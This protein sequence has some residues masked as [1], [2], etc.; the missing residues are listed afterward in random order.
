MQLGLQV[1]GHLALPTFA[2][3]TQSELS[4]IHTVSDKYRL[5]YY[6]DITVIILAK[7]LHAAINTKMMA[8]LESGSD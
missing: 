1:G 2:Q 5:G 8:N 4:K 6:Y 3:K 7:K